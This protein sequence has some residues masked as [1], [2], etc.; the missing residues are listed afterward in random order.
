MVRIFGYDARTVLAIVVIIAFF[1]AFVFTTAG[2]RALPPGSADLFHVLGAG[3]FG[4][5]R[6]LALPAA[7]PE[8]AVVFRLAAANAILVAMVAEFLMGTSGLGHLFH[9][10]RTD[11][12]MER[13]LGASAIAT[14]IS[15]PAFLGASRIERAARAGW[16]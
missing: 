3:T 10:A 6:L 5:L 1:P 16:G 11:L 14:V 9:A 8:W 13:A 7:I 15:V 2:L 12:A 4:R